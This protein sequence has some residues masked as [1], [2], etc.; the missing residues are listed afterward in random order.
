MK[1]GPQAETEKKAFII[2]NIFPSKSSDPV[3]MNIDL[4]TA[5]FSPTEQ[6]KIVKKQPVPRPKPEVEDF[7]PKFVDCERTTTT[8]TSNFLLEDSCELST[9]REFKSRSKFQPRKFSIVGRIITTKF[10]VARPK[11]H[12]GYQVNPTIQRFSFDSPSPDDKILAHLNKA[13]K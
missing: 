11:I 10:K 6:K 13:K 12:H 9:L 1:S 8:A 5:L 4:K 7:V 3:P 2:P